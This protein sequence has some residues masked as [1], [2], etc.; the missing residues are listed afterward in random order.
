[1]SVDSLLC[2]KRV[3]DFGLYVLMVSKLRYR[4]FPYNIPCLPHSVNKLEDV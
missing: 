4:I 1:M 2:G 3:R